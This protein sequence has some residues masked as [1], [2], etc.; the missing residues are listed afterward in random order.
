VHIAVVNNFFPPRPGG[1]SHL[2]D[3]LARGYA[4]A[5][6]DVLVL[7]A[8]YRDCPAVEERDGL[9]IARLPAWTLPQTPLTVS[10]DIAYT[11]RPSL[12][13]RVNRILDDFRPDVLH[14]HG[15][16][17]DL[18][19]ATG[20]YARKRGVPA[21]LSVHTRLA[22]PKPLYNAAFRAADATIV[23]PILRRYRPRFVV[24]D[25]QMEDYIHSRYRGAIEGI[26]Y[27]PVGVDPDQATGGD[28]RAVRAKLGLGSG[29]I[30]VSIG[31]VIPQRD[32][33]RLIRAMPRVLAKMPDASCVIIGGVYYDQFLKLAEELG[34][35][36]AIH[37]V[38]AVSRDEVRDY[39]AAAATEIHDLDGYGLGTASLESMAAG[40][41]IVAAVRSDN[42]PG[43]DLR[44][45]EHLLRVPV[46][47]DDALAEA[48]IEILA[49]P[50]EARRR[51]GEGGRKLVLEHFTLD[52][53]LGRHLDVLTRMAR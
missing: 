34:V 47:D 3:S 37:A 18:T 27:I 32:R 44:D 9:R 20:W 50:A 23:A 38:G 40:L 14:Q 8:A 42:F 41:P 5:G 19:W 39:L 1:S 45:G 13:R 22:S 28:E 30:V 24:M 35:R 6:H 36:H 53:V 46:D 11:L 43:L 48:I 52:R 25:I 33:T 26:E 29:P 4:A 10:F 12:Q 7:T 49:N 15:Q 51:V 21:L 31:H 2:S 17:F 16:F